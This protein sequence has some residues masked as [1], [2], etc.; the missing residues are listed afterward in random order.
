MDEPQT[1]LQAFATLDIRVGTIIAAQTFAQA[2]VPAYKLTLDFGA[3]IGTRRSSAQITDRYNVEELIGKHVLAVVNFPP[4]R[5]AGF[6]SEV[7]VLG[8]P[9]EHGAV[10]LVQ[11][12]FPVPAGGRLY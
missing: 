11:P 5:I 8:V 9:D 2:R 7:L 6:L 12:D 4:K 3:P 10:V 1:P